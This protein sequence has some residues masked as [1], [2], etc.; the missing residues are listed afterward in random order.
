M[1]GV[2]HVSAPHLALRPLR[3]TDLPSVLAIQRAAYG[4]GYQESA[5]VLGRKLELAP[6][7]CWL[8]HAGKEA[9]GYVFAHPWDAAGAPALHVPL[10][11]L[12]AAAD[13]GFVHDLA[14]SPA[15]RGLGV[16]AALF[17]RVRAWSG[18]AGHRGMRLVALAD[19]VPF[20]GHHGFTTLPAALPEA[21]GAGALLMECAFR[22]RD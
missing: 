22:D 16:A 9:V 14:V 2:G 19:A 7:A 12:P 10:A 18:A 11:A 15:A 4:D 3:P 17:A 20:W 13:R 5:T 21:Y 8:A 6:Q 1:A